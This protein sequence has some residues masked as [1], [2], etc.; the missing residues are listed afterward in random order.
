MRPL[1]E[2]ITAGKVMDKVFV[3][4]GLRGDLFRE[5]RE[6]LHNHGIPYQQVPEEKL[7]RIT[8]R[9]HQGIIA[10]VSPIDFGDLQRYWLQHSSAVKH[11]SFCCSMESPM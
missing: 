7:N 3:Q 10:F 5:L 2:A 4:K 8:T 6:L 1:A 9:N 11:Q